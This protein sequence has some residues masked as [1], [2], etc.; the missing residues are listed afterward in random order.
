[1]ARILRNLGWGIAWGLAFA[2]LLSLFVAVLAVLRG[3]AYFDP[4]DLHLSQIAG[5]YVL[6]GILA[7]SVAGL[8]RPLIRSRVGGTFVGALVGPFVYGTISFAMGDRGGDLVFVAL[9]AGL[10]VGALSG[11]WFSRRS[12]EAITPE[13]SGGRKH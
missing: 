11:F 2:A 5:L 1:V 12:A 10:P 13:T 8:F 9:V 4:Y 6:A 7:G 3:S